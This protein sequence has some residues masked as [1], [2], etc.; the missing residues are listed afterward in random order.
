LKSKGI[1]KEDIQKYTNLSNLNYSG[2]TDTE[3]YQTLLKSLD[4]PVTSENMK[5]L[6]AWRQAEGK[7]GKNNPFNTTWDLP[8]STDFNS[9]GVK[10]YETPRDGLVATV[11]TLKNGKYDC[12]LNGLRKDMG[13]DRI[14]RCESLKTWGTGDLVAKVVSSYNSGAK[15]KI[16]NLA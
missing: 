2:S 3:F 6:L 8:G 15:P 1:K 13:A 5:F 7:G 10:N 4:A 9:V 14:S 16:S 12:I 11:K